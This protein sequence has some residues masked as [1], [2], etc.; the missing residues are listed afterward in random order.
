MHLRRPHM[1]AASAHK[2]PQV[3]SSKLTDLHG[4]QLAREPLRPIG[5]VLWTNGADAKRSA[6]QGAPDQPT[7]KKRNFTTHP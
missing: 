2:E 4:P 7:N 1:V 6:L 3:S 5:R